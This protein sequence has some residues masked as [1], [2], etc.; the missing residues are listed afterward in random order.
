[1]DGTLWDAVPSYCKVWDTTAAELGVKRSPVQYDELVSNMGKPLRE[2]YVTIMG[3]Y[4]SDPDRFMSTLAAVE[5]RL[6]PELGGNLYP[7]VASTLEWLSKR[8]R[9][10]M[11]SNCTGRGLDNFLTINNLK[12]YFTDWLSYGATGVDKDVNIRRL[13]DCYNLKRPVYVGD[14]QRD[15]DSTHEAG[16]EFAWAAYGFG[17]AEGYDFRI[18][19][20]KDLENI[21]LGHGN[22]I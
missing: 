20:F 10:F 5:D 12:P 4:D 7:D 13:V 11:I 21:V 8:V 22:E 2:I 19:R 6:M 3:P 14:I 1:M 15:C 18:D 9:L 16:I 17:T